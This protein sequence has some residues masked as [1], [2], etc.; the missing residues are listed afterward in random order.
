VPHRAA[1]LAVRHGLEADLLLVCHELRDAFVF[2]G[3]ERI[4]GD[5]AG[6]EVCTGA[7]KALG[8]QEASHDIVGMGRLL[9][10]HALLLLVEGHAE[11]P[12]PERSVAIAQQVA[13]TAPYRKLL[14]CEGNP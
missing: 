6:S 7:F 12:C 3:G 8:T 5:L 4:T 14:I 10:G 1:E 13:T 9:D 11:E 2:D